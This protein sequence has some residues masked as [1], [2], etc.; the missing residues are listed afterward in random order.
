MI[1]L[2]VDP[3]GASRSGGI[4]F[5]TIAQALQEAEKYA[6][7]KV[8]IEIAAGVY[9]ERLEIHQPDISFRGM[10]CMNTILTYDDYAKCILPDGEKRGTFRTPTLFIDADRFHAANMTF[11]NS[12]GRG[13]DVGQALALYVDGDGMVFENCRISG[14]QDT[15]FTGPLPPFPY[16]KNGFRGPKENAPRINGRHYYVNC[17][18]SG[19]VD[20]IFGS[21]TALFEDCEIFSRDLGQEIN[22][23]VTAASTPQGQ[24]YGYVLNRCRF[25]GECKPGSVYLG[26]PWRNYARTVI[27]NSYLGR[28]IHPA[29]FHDWNKNEAHSTV[30][31]AEYK[32]YGPGADTSGRAAFVRQ[33]TDAEAA[34]FTLE[35]VL[36][37]M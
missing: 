10:G 21:A 16:E 12:A 27:L 24:T 6:G 11:E 17:F 9:R 28:H 25:T 13:A 31:Y 36:G 22:G 19:D 26:R 30:F 2:K 8:I 32:N 35:K 37:D 20:F 5:R 33:L 1:T 4:F 7:D 14:S 18:I 3:D 15:L 23:Y 34:G 29:G